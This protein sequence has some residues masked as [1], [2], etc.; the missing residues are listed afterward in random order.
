MVMDQPVMSRPHLVAILIRSTINQQ[1]YPQLSPRLPVQ[2]APHRRASRRQVPH[3]RQLAISAAHR[4]H[5]PL[6]HQARHRTLTSHTRTNLAP[7]RLRQVH[8]DKTEALA[9]R[10]VQRPQQ[11]HTLA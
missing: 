2:Q 4:L 8:R 1:V 3:R 6:H 11:A 9:H 7:R 5:R 10:Q